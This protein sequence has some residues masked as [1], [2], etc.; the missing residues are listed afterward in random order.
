[1]TAR[2]I[3]LSSRRWPAPPDAAD[4]R[5]AP[6]SDTVA[7]DRGKPAPLEIL[8]AE[9]YSK[10]ILTKDDFVKACAGS[11]V[12]AGLALDRWLYPNGRPKS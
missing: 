8:A 9:M 7:A 3:P 6:V 11:Q 10:D 12:R 2:I 5:P 1:M 4:P